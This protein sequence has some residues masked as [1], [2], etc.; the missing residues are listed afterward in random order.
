MGPL[1]GSGGFGSVYSGTRL[2]D[3]APVSDGFLVECALS[4]P[5]SFPIVFALPASPVNSH[6]LLSL[7]LAAIYIKF[8]FSLPPPFVFEGGY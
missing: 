8:L 3:G 4:Q 1:L 2:A 5:P 7:A 6:I